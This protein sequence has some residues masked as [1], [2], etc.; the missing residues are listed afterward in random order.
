MGVLLLDQYTYLHFATGIVSYFWGISFWN[1]IILHS[2]FEFFENSDIG[3]NFI[4]QY[5][6]FWPGGKPYTDTNINILGDTIGAL[7]GW[8]SAK[9]LDKFSTK[10]HLYKPHM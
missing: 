7:I 10:Y 3:K 6:T 9:I 4:N 1:F 5:L 2:A 8:L